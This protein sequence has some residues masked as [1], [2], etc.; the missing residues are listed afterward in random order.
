MLL[1]L[2]HASVSLQIEL[3][4]ASSASDCR[5]A[6]IVAVGDLQVVPLRP[7]RPPIAFLEGDARVLGNLLHCCSHHIALIVVYEKQFRISR[8]QKN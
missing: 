3:L 2:C 1:N 6:A 7:R 5:E 8:A 4:R